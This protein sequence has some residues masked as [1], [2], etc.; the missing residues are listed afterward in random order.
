MFYLNQRLINPIIHSETF[1]KIVIYCDLN[2]IFNAHYN[3]IFLFFSALMFH[4]THVLLN[5]FF[6]VKPAY[7]ILL[8]YLYYD[9]ILFPY[10]LKVFTLKFS[11]SV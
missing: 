2:A 4:K 5:T 9:F 6:I 11:P 3:N 1:T 7:F 8:Y 10:Y